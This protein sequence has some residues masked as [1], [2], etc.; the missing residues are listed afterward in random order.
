MQARARLAGTA[1]VALAVLLAAVVAMW[2]PSRSTNSVQDSDSGQSAGQTASPLEAGE[3]TRRTPGRGFGRDADRRNGAA[4]TLRLPEKMHAQDKWRVRLL[5]RDNQDRPIAGASASIETGD[6]ELAIWDGSGLS[7]RSGEILGS[8]GSAALRVPEEDDVRL[9]VTAPGYAPYSKATA[10]KSWTAGPNDRVIRLSQSGTMHI[11]VRDQH[12]VPAAMAKLDLHYGGT[13]EK[14]A[15]PPEFAFDGYE[16][17]RS[18]VVDSL[19]QATIQDLHQGWW[20]VDPQMCKDWDRG[21]DYVIVRVTTGAPLAVNVP[22]LRADPEEYA[23]MVLE[24]PPDALLRDFALRDPLYK[25]WVPA[26]Q[27]GDTT[28]Y[29]PTERWEEFE[30]EVRRIST[31]KVQRIRLRS[32]DHLRRIGWNP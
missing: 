25:Q 12:G 4:E 8:L 29:M 16:S 30:I 19:G 14:A 26:F 17:Y 10:R 3:D 2:V 11:L 7:S 32:G 23:S 5:I 22:V 28:I 6:Q 13:A 20:R 27:Y 15:D 24:L 21:E 18:V 31:G 9:R 1:A